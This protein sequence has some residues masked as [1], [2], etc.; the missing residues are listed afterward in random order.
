MERHYNRSFVYD[1]VAPLDV[2]HGRGRSRHE[3]PRDR[4]GLFIEHKIGELGQNGG[5]LRVE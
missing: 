2:V 4:Q 5:E 1:V 3:V